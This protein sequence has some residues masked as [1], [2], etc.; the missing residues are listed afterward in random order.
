MESSLLLG[1]PGALPFL[2]HLRAQVEVPGARLWAAG[3]VFNGGDV[4]EAYE[5]SRNLIELIEGLGKGLEKASRHDLLRLAW[6]A[7]Q[8]DRLGESGGADLQL[9][10]TAQDG[11]GV[12]VAAVGLSMVYGRIA[13]E[14]EPLV[15][16]DHPLLCPPGIPTSLPGVL[17][18]DRPTDQVLGIPDHLPA[19]LPAELDLARDCGW[20][21]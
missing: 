18:L 10:L 5:A 16:A 19:E 4:V 20:T 9:L 11:E 3:R 12:G 15:S 14:L 17:T 8:G 21:G 13:G 6:E 1:D 2:G 7:L